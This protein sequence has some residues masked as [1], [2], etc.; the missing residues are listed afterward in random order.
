MI[1]DLAAKASAASLVSGLTTKQDVIQDGG[2]P[3]AKVANLVLDLAAK[4][5][6]ASLTNGLA[7]KQDVIQ[8]GGLSPAKVSGLVADLAAQASSASLTTGLATKQDVLTPASN[9]SVDTV[10]SRLYLGDVF[11]FWKAIRAARC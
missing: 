11:R 1:A 10:S 2:L 9:L 7:T 4:A 6:A 5:S 3:Q 8:D